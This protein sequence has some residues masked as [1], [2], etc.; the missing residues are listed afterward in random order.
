MRDLAIQASCP[1]LELDPSGK[2]LSPCGRFFGSTSAGEGEKAGADER[3]QGV[4]VSGLVSSLA[5]SVTTL[6][7]ILGSSGGRL[8]L[9]A[10][11]L[12][13][14]V[15]VT[16]TFVYVTFVPVVT[17][18]AT[19]TTGDGTPEMVLM[20]HYFPIYSVLLSF[21]LQHTTTAVVAVR[22]MT[23]SSAV[24]DRLTV[25]ERGCTCYR[26]NLIH[27]TQVTPPFTT[28]LVG[29]SGIFRSLPFPTFRGRGPPRPRCLLRNFSI[30][31]SFSLS[32]ASS[33][34]RST[35]SSYV[36]VRVFLS[37]VVRQSSHVRV[38]ILLMSQ[39]L[40]SVAP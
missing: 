10:F 21:Q 36:W 30:W 9:L 18:F 23:G 22:G 16:L 7:P 4:K 38:G 40:G 2:G 17:M 35:R 33:I 26:F 3:L 27:G 14:F 34:S 15:F 31:E 8:C 20:G 5:S 19:V 12:L 11:S 13:L 1:F 32:R 29:V 39:W 24:I 25:E 37:E 6:V 28:T